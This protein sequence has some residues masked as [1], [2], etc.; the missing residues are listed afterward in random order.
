ML[1][2]LQFAFTPGPGKGTTS[3]LV[4]IYNELVSFLDRPGTIRLLQLD[5]SKAFDAINHSAIISVLKEFKISLPGITW[6][7]HYLHER[8][9]MVRSGTESSSWVPVTSGVPQGSVL[10]PL[11]FALT[12]NAFSPQF[13]NRTLMVK[14]ADDITII[15]KIRPGEV[16]LS[17]AELKHIA[18]SAAAVG[19]SLNGKKCSVLSLSTVKNAPLLPVFLKDIPLNTVNS[20]KILGVT[21]SSDLKWKCHI[22]ITIAKVRRLS[23]LCSFL[24]RSGCSSDWCWKFYTAMIRSIALYAFPAWCNT[25]NNL[26][27]QLWKIEKR[28][29][30]VIGST[31]KIKIEDA[32]IALCSS[33]FTSISTKQHHPLTSLFD[34]RSIRKSDRL[35]SNKHH[36]SVPYAHTSRYKNSF[37]KFASLPSTTPI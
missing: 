17:T 33:L 6:I 25:P 14:Y 11:L 29:I 28:L 9:Q 3:A 20:L 23:G 1:D 31:P 4:T 35:S 10:G 18:T 22:D 8:C 2:P 7:Q 32:A 13:P 16:D 34:I 24:R 15:H 19:L 5:F 26:L 12:V 21:F 36:L 37:I 27:T 30:K